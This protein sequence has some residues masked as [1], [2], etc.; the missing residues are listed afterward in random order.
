MVTSFD[1][2]IDWP[3]VAVFV[4]LA[5]R[6]YDAAARPRSPGRTGTMASNRTRD[7]N[8]ELVLQWLEAY[9]T[10]DPSKYEH[11]LAD[12]PYYRPN[13]HEYRGKEGFAEIARI[14]RH[15]YPNGL[16]R[17]VEAAVVDGD[18]VAMR[19]ITRAVTNKGVDYENNYALFFELT[20]A[21]KILKQY[22]YLDTDY[23][24]QMF[25]RTGL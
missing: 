25:D 10:F 18:T 16:T 21:G 2:A 22:E 13:R 11:L 5:Q 9:C 1:P 20:A 24:N 4:M 7:E 3:R 8:V 19:V 17:E 6:G 15:F 14:A 23:S 12:E